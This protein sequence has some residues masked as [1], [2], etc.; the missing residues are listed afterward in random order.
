MNKKISL[1]IA[2]GLIAL[3]AAA[4]FIITYNY[5]MKVFNEKVKSVAEKEGIYSRLSEL[6]KYIRANYISNI[7]EDAL[8]DSIMRGYVEGLGDKYA[9]YYSAEEY[10]A[11]LQKSE[12]VE[13]SPGFTWDKEASGYI[14]IVSVITG[15]SAD[16]A[17]LMA[18]DIITAV[19]NTDVIA[20]ENGYDEAVGL[21]KSAEGTKIKLHIKRVNSQGISEFF[22]VDVTSE[23]NEIVSVTGRIIGESTGYIKIT[24]FNDKTP[25]QFDSVMND[26]I[27]DGAKELVMDVRNNPG[28]AM[29][30]LQG[31]LDCILGDCD[32]VTA[33]FAGKD[34]V[35]VK[36]TEAEKVSMP[37]VV[38]VNENTASSAELFALGLRDNAQAQLVGSHTY[39]KG[40][41][42][43]T[44]KL[45]GGAA[46][47]ITV[48]TL[49]TKN[50]GNYNNVGI[51]PD[52]E[53]TL[54][55]DVDLSLL[56]ADDQLL[57]DTQLVKAIEVVQT[58]G[59]T[60]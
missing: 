11:F 57:S 50:S 8:N 45:T 54:P 60:K 56:T 26:L 15:S 24:A 30:S 25:D 33:H 23:K 55:A 10:S 44:H 6:D 39:G 18:D 9:E 17:G 36:T 16:K 43:Y 21:L 5:S 32:V 52:F 58:I 1:G 34:E 40:V 12:G 19:N 35:A 4:T 2:I 49:T 59:N 22:S 20:F 42:Q 14:H 53:V 13:V 37:M 48:A 38:L 28:G 27:A 46:V 29:E 41:M 7:D 31:T 47:K 51:K 3:A